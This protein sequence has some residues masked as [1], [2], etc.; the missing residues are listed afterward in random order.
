MGL[1][2]L[3]KRDALHIIHH[4]IG[5]I[6]RLEESPDADNARLLIKACQRSGFL[7][8]VFPSLL[9][10]IPGVRFCQGDLAGEIVIARRH[11]GRKVF[12]DC[13][14]VA[15]HKIAAKVGN[16]ETALPEHPAYHVFPVED[17]AGSQLMIWGGNGNGVSAVRAIQIGLI[18]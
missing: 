4:Q 7:Q 11:T 15:Q 13:N 9:V 1:D 3:F 10:R 14:T 5:C 8:E 16:A 17:R 12:L 18:F 2:V 6:V